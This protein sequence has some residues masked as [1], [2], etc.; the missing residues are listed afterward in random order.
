VKKPPQRNVCFV[1]GTRAEFGLM[2]S[3]LRAI[4]NHPKLNLQLVATGMHLDPTHGNGLDSIR[5]QG[6]EIDRVVAW[7]PTGGRAPEPSP[8]WLARSTG[9]AIT[10]L[11]D[12]LA[13]L[14]A[15]IVLVVGDRVEAFAAATAAHLGGRIV[16]HVHGGDRAAGQVDDSLR[17][18][19]TKLAHVHFPA[20]RQSA[21]R[22]KRLG[23]DSWRI[24]HCG[25]PG[26]DGIKSTA[27]PWPDIVAAF[28]HLGRRQYALVVY[29]P[30]DPSESV[31]CRRAKLLIDAVLTAGIAKVIIIYPNNDP[32]AGGIVSAWEKL[33]DPRVL[34]QRD[35]PRPIFLGLMRDAAMLVG[36]SSSGIIE[37]GSFGTPVMDVGPRQNG[38]E[39]GPN[40]TH[41]PFERRPLEG[42]LLKL[43]NKGHPKPF[44]SG[45]IY[46]GEG[47]GGKIADVLA[48]LEISEKLRRKLICY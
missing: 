7:R 16:A 21:D 25:S 39:R 5:Q 34:C 19:I 30:T 18:A 9:V 23:E 11:A 3:T 29:H 40:V 13:E 41:I 33:E 24:H 15:E 48:G 26:I 4:T 20:T 10:G 37:A 46:G 28:P 45:N 2:Q 22:L 17:H 38:R 35:V 6:W 42:A 1:T 27:A 12:A 36:N 31:E 14:S 47:A 44:K 8:Q 32:G 43:W